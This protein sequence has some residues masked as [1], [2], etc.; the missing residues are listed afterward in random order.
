MTEN[1]E[2]TFLCGR[3][4]PD[5]L[6]LLSRGVIRLNNYD[7]N[8]EVIQIRVQLDDAGLAYIVPNKTRMVIARNDL[9]IAVFGRPRIKLLR[10]LERGANITQDLID[11]FSPMYPKPE[12]IYGRRCTLES[13]ITR[14]Q[15]QRQHQER[16]SNIMNQYSK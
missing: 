9:I 11:C 2:V 14:K 7:V 5:S 15:N 10:M 3:V 16:I 1:N 4:M 13:V 8:G 12:Q 6:N